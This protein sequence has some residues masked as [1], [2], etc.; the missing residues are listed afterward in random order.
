L[1][2]KIGSIIDASKYKDNYVVKIYDAKDKL[3]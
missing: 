3:L 1:R 2:D